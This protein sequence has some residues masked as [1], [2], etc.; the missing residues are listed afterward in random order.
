MLEMHFLDCTVFLPAFLMDLK[1]SS[2]LQQ[3]RSWKKDSEHWVIFFM[4]PS[5]KAVRI[6]RTTVYSYLHI[7]FA[8]GS[9]DFTHFCDTWGVS[10]TFP[11][12]MRAIK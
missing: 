4:K 1:S 12:I 8:T 10:R 11:K 6:E 7:Y 2:V 5:T 3:T 9:T